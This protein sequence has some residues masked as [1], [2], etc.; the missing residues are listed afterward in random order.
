MNTLKEISSIG[1]IIQFW[2]SGDLLLLKVGSID[3]DICISL[4]LSVQ[5]T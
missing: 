4:C 3:I 1:F 2:C 5:L